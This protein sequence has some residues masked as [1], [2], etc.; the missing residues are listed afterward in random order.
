MIRNISKI[1]KINLQLLGTYHYGWSDRSLTLDD[2]VSWALDSNNT[3]KVSHCDLGLLGLIWWKLVLQVASRKCLK[4]KMPQQQTN[5]KMAMIRVS[6]FNFGEPNSKQLITWQFWE[7]FG[8]NFQKHGIQLFCMKFLKK[9]S[10]GVM[11]SQ[12]FDS[13]WEKISSIF[14][15]STRKIKDKNKRETIRKKNWEKS[16]KISWITNTKYFCGIY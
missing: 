8:Y 7:L 3:S 6:N 11:K 2:E 16:P 4:W 14:Y 12:K 5:S 13:M 9:Y 10:S 1:R 15:W